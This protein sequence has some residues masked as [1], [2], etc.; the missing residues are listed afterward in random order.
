MSEGWIKVHREY[1][2]SDLWKSEKFTKGQAWLDMNVNAN[3][4]P[5]S[6]W[7]RGVEIKVL[8]GQLGM[9]ETTMSKRWTWSRNKVRRFLKW[10]E[11][12]QLIKQQKNHITSIISITN[13]HM[14]QKR[15]QDTIQQAEQQTIQQKDSKRYTNKNE[16]NLKNEKNN[17][18]N[19]K[20]ENPKSKEYYRLLALGITFSVLRC[21]YLKNQEGQ[22]LVNAW[23]AW[24]QINPSNGQAK[25]IIEAAAN[26]AKFNKVANVPNLDTWL[27][28][29]YYGLTIDAAMSDWLFVE[30]YCWISCDKKTFDCDKC[31]KLWVKVTV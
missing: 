7:V 5:G 14:E 22:S 11:S 24:E 17:K 3:H 15:E 28:E 9:S 19:A 18:L 8:R 21:F 6:F 27:Y 1:T 26:Q 30:Q 29:K 13:Y 2:N 16:K 4:A 25:K 31:G 23:N 20:P 10:L 12:K